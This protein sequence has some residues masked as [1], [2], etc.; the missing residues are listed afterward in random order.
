LRRLCFNKNEGC[1]DRRLSE[2]LPSKTC[3]DCP[4]A[5]KCQANRA[6]QWHGKT[7]E[8]AE[9]DDAIETNLK[10]VTENKTA[11]QQRKEIIEHPFGTIKRSYGYYYTLLR[12]KKRSQAS[13][14]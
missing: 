8:R 2:T 10:R 11:Y 3:L 1:F 13:S 6:K 4:F 12:T 9:F 7:I 14:P 5:E